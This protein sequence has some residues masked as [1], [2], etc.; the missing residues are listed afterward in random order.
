MN[1][2]QAINYGANFLKSVNNTNSILDSEILLSS[3]LKVER[4]DL[5][6]KLDDFVTDNEKKK[7]LDYLNRRKINEPISYILEGKEFWNYNFFIEKGVLIPRPETELLVENIL[8]N[9]KNKN[10]FYNILEIGT[11][12]GCIIISLLKELKLSRGIGIE[13]SKKAL[14]ISKRNSELLKVN[15][16]LKFYLV[17][18][19]KFKTFQKFDIIVSN[20]PYIP[21]YRITNLSEDIKRFEPKSA[22]SGGKLGYEFTEKIIKISSKFLKKNGILA[23]E[24][25]DNQFQNVYKILKKNGFRVSIKSILINKQVRNVVAT[26]L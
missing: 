18:L 13:V 14:Q 6:K 9:K 12:S 23:L 17:D 3:I 19:K 26:K 15:E 11:G 5:I 7:F 25:G 4:V 21:E 16:R 8:K 22:L 24:M 10:Y 2:Q 20:P 1:V